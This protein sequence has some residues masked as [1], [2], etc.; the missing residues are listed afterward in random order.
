MLLALMKHAFRLKFDACP[1]NLQDSNA[2][3]A[4][5]V[6]SEALYANKQTLSENRV[7]FLATMFIKSVLGRGT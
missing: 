3:N 6:R 4:T 2:L 1:P 7:Y 5:R